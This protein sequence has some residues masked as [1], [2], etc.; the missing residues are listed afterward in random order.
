MADSVGAVLRM[1]IF[2]NKILLTVLAVLLFVPSIV[3]IVYYSNNKGGKM[4]PS[5]A[6]TL[7]VVDTEGIKYT[8]IKDSG[9]EADKMFALFDA[10]YNGST[11]GT[12]LP[13]VV[14]ASP[15]FSVT[16]SIDNR[17]TEY[18]YYLSKGATNA[19]FTD[20]FGGVWQ[21][22][23][24]DAEAFLATEYA[25][26]VHDGS[27][28]PTLLLSGE[29]GVSPASATW[30][31]KNA[32]GT[33]AEANLSALIATAPQSFTLDGGLSLEFS[34]APD[35]ALITVTGEDGTVL[36]NDS[37]AN[38]AA[39]NVTGGTKV[40]I[41][42]EAHWYEDAERS[43]YGDL[44]YSFD[45]LVA[46]TAEFYPGINSITA[47]EFIS[48]TALNVKDPTK[49]TFSS[50]PDIGFTPTFVTDE[51]DTKYVRALIPFDEK[52]AAGTYALTFGYA[53]TSQV[54]NIEV[55]ARDIRNNTY[56]VD[57][58]I[59]DSYYTESARNVFHTTVD[60]IVENITPRALWKG[61][62][63]QHPANTYAISQGFGHR[64]TV[65]GY[66][67][68][69]NNPAVCYSSAANLDVYAANDGVVEFAGILEISGYTVIID[70]GFGLKTW[71]CHMSECTVAPGD[72]VSREDVVGKTGNTGF[73]N[74]NG[75]DFVMTVCGEY[76]SPYPTWADGA[77]VD[78]NGVPLYY[79]D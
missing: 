64:R 16:Y 9:E 6:D 12:S 22:R 71:Y 7:T 56:T 78:L 21:I 48:V 66:D 69:Y 70:H 20:S 24:E 2:K 75:V 52:L 1:N 67:I 19:Y 17:T 79:E 23:T 55:A 25:Q 43:F 44:S 8:F 42:V 39:L 36:F 40:S 30:M 34:T 4:I 10:M 26:N 63:H 38:I 53:G 15:P 13:D 11:K 29:F 68:S 65:S 5:V 58:A 27:K 41:G 76:V 50:T 72:T 31:Y 37:L 73:T 45:A 33:F 18:K 28:C 62:F 57:A 14:S 3:S 54:V 46:D 59:V 32:T 60:E 74:Q 77:W 51:S 47:G 61:Y 35:N 49:I